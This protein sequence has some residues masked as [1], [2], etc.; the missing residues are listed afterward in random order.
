MMLQIL[1]YLLLKAAYLSQCD[2][3]FLCRKFRELLAAESRDVISRLH[4][5]ELQTNV[6]FLLIKILAL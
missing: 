1:Q 4:V 2:I 5:N 3:F 6:N